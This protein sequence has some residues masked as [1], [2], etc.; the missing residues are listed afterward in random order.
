MPTNV[1]RPLTVVFNTGYNR[2]YLAR[3][4]PKLFEDGVSKRTAKEES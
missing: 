3:H 4:G 2:G 1:W